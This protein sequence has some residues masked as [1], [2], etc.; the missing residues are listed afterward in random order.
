M[1]LNLKK[2]GTLYKTEIDGD[3][4]QYGW[5]ESGKAFIAKDG[6]LLSYKEAYRK[7][8]PKPQPLYLQDFFYTSTGRQYRKSIDGIV[9]YL[10]DKYCKQE[11]GQQ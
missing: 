4:Y 6:E 2:V 3:C 8:A 9:H 10:I 11:G 5:Y 1:K 7:F